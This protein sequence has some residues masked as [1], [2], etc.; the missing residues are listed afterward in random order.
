MQLLCRRKKKKER[1]KIKPTSTKTSFLFHF[2]HS[3]S[4]QYLPFLL[5]DSLV[6]DESCTDFLPVLLV[7]LLLVQEAEVRTVVHTGLHP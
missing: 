1:Q 3:T 7:S 4:V 2:E 6:C 5:S